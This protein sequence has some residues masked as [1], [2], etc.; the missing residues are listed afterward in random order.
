MFSQDFA[1]L[2]TRLTMQDYPEDGQGH[3]SQ[4]QHGSKMLVDIPDDLALPSVQVN[5]KVYF[6]NE[7]LQQSTN[8]YFIPMK[9]FQA[10][11]GPMLETEVLCLE[12]R[13]LQT[14]VSSETYRF[15]WLHLSLCRKSCSWSRASHCPCLNLFL[16]IR[17]AFKLFTGPFHIY[18]IHW[19]KGWAD[20]NI[21]VISFF[22]RA[23]AQSTPHKVRRPVG[24]HHVPHHLCQWMMHQWTFQSSGTN[25]MW[26]TVTTGHTHGQL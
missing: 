9:L 15:S 11:V 6:V 10:W 14:D 2:L 24:S 7:L 19:N 5:G 1:N 20:G 21:R 23:H 26:S 16:H 8:G 12:Y 3:M 18:T 4:V 13:V 22:S 17:G 25:I